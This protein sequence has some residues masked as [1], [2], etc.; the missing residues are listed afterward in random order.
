[1]FKA[2]VLSIFV[3]AVGVYCAKGYEILQE[4]IDAQ[5]TKN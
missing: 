4:T 1:M 2:G 3:I 5:V